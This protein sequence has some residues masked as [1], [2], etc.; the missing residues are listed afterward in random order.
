MKCN[1]LLRLFLP[2]ANADYYQKLL[3]VGRLQSWNGPLEIDLSIYGSELS[4]LGREQSC[5]GRLAIDLYKFTVDNGQRLA[6]YNL[7]IVHWQLI[8]VK[9]TA[10]ISASRSNVS[11]IINPGWVIFWNGQCGL[12]HSVYTFKQQA[13]SSLF[14][15]FLFLNE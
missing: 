14:F 7:V 5:N 2:L 10:R 15:F 9:S 11:K 12:F 6:D 8:H 13:S 4:E 1:Q 3:L